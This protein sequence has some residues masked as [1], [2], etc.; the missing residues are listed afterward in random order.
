MNARTWLRGA[1]V[2]IALAGLLDPTLTTRRFARAEVQLLATSPARDSALVA[3]VVRRLGR[4]FRAVVGNADAADATILIGDRPPAQPEALR[5]PLVAVVPPRA[6]AWLAMERVTV[7]S[8]AMEHERVV[9]TAL[10]HAVGLKGQRLEV[11][12]HDGPRLVARTVVTPSSSDERLTAS[13]PLVATSV[14]VVPLRVNA[15]GAG[16]AGDA[17]DAMIEVRSGQYDVLAF[18]LRPSWQATFVRRALDADGRLAVASRMV[19][20]RGLSSARGTA[21]A[22]L[23]DPALLGRYRVVL[24]GSPGQLGAAEVTALERFMRGRGGRVVLL[25]DQLPTGPVTRLLGGGA[26]R[27]DSSG[28]VA[29]VVADS[30]LGRLRG[31]SLVVPG[32]LPGGASVMAAAGPGRP[33]IW[34]LPVGEGEVVVVGLLDAWQRRG[35]GESDFGRFW[36]TLVAALAAAVPPPIEL[37]LERNVLAPGDSTEVR[38]TLSDLAGGEPGG[39][40]VEA[41]LVDSAGRRSIVRLWPGLAAGSLQGRV[42]PGRAGLAR[43]EVRRGDDSASIPIFVDSSATAARPGGDDLLA[44]WVAGAGGVRVAGDNLARLPDVVHGLIGTPPVPEPWHPMR[45]PWWILP[46]ACL[47]AT[48]WWLRRRAGDA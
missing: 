25:L 26:W 22:D 17:A 19:T 48:E 35:A 1:A 13:L 39:A 8:A 21:P 23:T 10:L 32:R 40:T 7:P 15:R 6:S 16:L 42:R 29:D 5:G 30:S 11:T 47:L 3:S 43:V 31:A 41:S 18:D 44:A 37:S 20:S 14:G 38:V 24:V 34:S 2:A 28:R 12:L 4:D 9:V 27:H 46:F 36:P 33:V 45:S